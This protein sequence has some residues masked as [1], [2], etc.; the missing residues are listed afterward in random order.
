MHGHIARSCP[1]PRQQRDREATGRKETSVA[2][3]ESVPEPA[4]GGEATLTPAERVES[5]RRNLHEAELAATV[6]STSSVIGNVTLSSSPSRSSLGPTITSR[7]EVNGITTE[8]VIDTGSPVTIISLDFAMIVMAKER[9]KYR[10][11]EE[12]EDA[13]LK[14]F[15]PP[16]ITLKSYG[17][18]RLDVLA[19][20]PVCIT[21]GGYHSDVKVLV[22]KDAPTRLLL[23]T[24]A[25]PLLGYLLV[26]KETEDCGVN[27]TTGETVC[28][29]YKEA[30]TVPETVEAGEPQSGEEPE[31]KGLVAD[32]EQYEVNPTRPG[33][34]RLLNATRILAGYQK[35]VRAKVEG[36]LETKCHYSL[37]RH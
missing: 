10:N 25:Q 29:K 4:S 14:K 24:D 36:T 17:G 23:G 18:E 16:E 31:V 34:V 12:W 1:Y 26:K 3:V 33:V 32:E 22:R 19:Q 28:L 5:L 11:V 27:L 2:C 8:A 9:S 13:T 21:Q 15:E 20:L 7:V 35:M 37:Q 30:E 6:T